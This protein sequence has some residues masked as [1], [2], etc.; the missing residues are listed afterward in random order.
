MVACPNTVGQDFH[1]YIVVAVFEKFRPFCKILVRLKV[2][3]DLLPFAKNC[4][5]WACMTVRLISR[6]PISA[7]SLVAMPRALIVGGVLN[8]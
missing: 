5:R 3:K 2:F 4:S 7:M 8:S 1:P 6:S